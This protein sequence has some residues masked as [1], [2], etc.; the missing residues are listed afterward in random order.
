MD[1]DAAITH[2]EARPTGDLQVKHKLRRARFDGSD[3][4]DTFERADRVTNFEVACHRPTFT[5]FPEPMDRSRGDDLFSEFDLERGY[6]WIVENGQDGSELQGAR[7]SILNEYFV[8]YAD[9]L[10]R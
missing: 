9:R 8:A 7:I 2:E 1:K 6:G 4:V 3:S 5:G 10:D